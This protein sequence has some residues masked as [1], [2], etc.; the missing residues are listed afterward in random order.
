MQCDE[1][2]SSEIDKG[3]YVRWAYYRIYPVEDS[4]SVKLFS[5]TQYSNRCFISQTVMDMIG[6]GE[7]DKNNNG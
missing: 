6:S 7:S 5:Y 4:Y 2:M 1:V 3:Y